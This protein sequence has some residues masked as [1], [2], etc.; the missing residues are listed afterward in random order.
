LQHGLVSHREFKFLNIA[1]IR[2]I[3]STD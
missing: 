3:Q 1:V 2:K